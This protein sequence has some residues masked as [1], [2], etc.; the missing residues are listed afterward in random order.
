VNALQRIHRSLIPGGVLLDL[1]PSLA[2]AP[3]VSASGVLGRLDEREFR[4]FADRVNVLLQQTIS[5]G[6]LMQ[7]GEVTFTVVHRFS[8]ATQLLADVET[9][10]GTRVPFAVR[11]R[12]QRAEPPSKCK[13]A[14]ACVGY[15]R[16]K[17]RWNGAARISS[18]IDSCRS[19][20]AASLSRHK[21]LRPP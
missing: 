16:Y 5:A 12:L 2:N 9:W 3:V 14:R 15:V 7:E 11:K 20:P 10:M 8:E 21:V 18:W 17:R 1:Q 19:R 4:A 6:L 13:K